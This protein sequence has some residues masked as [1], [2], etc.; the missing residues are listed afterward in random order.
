MAQLAISSLVEPD[1]LPG[2]DHEPPRSGFDDPKVTFASEQR[3]AVWLF[4]GRET[5][6]FSFA[7]GVDAEKS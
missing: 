4:E 7:P 2:R 5:A 6:S 1:V 3:I